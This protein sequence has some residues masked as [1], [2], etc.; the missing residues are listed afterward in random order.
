[1]RTIAF[2]AQ[3]F[4]E[5]VRKAAGVEPLLSPPIMLKNF[6]PELLNGAQF[7][8]FKLHGFAG[9]G[10]WYGDH[11]QTAVSARQIE[12]CDLKDAIVFVANCFA[13][14]PDGYPDRMACALFRAGVKAIVA[15]VGQN[16]AQSRAVSGADQLGFIFRRLV[17]AAIPY[18][19][20]FEVCMEG[21]AKRAQDTIR[22]GRSP[23]EPD[24]DTL[25]FKLIERHTS[26]PCNSPDPLATHPLPDPPNSP[27]PLL[28]RLK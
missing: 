22:S 18:N 26:D 17:S 19:E 4:A 8:Y 20:A 9:Q 11:M 2:C 28:E 25:Q 16:F 14:T 21:L 5:S 3:Q 15:G 23:T 10:Y 6:Q 12:T 24:L 27:N 13:L 1:M 7:L